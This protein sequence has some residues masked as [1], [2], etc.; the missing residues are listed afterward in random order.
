MKPPLKATA[1]M[2]WGWKRW[3]VLRVPRTTIC[4]RDS[5]S[6]AAGELVLRQES[7]EFRASCLRACPATIRNLLGSTYA[8]MKKRAKISRRKIHDLT[9]EKSLC[10]FA[11]PKMMWSL[12][13]VV[14]ATIS[15][16]P[17]YTQ[18]STKSEGPSLADSNLSSLSTERAL[19]KAGSAALDRH[20]SEAIK[21]L[22]T[23]LREH[24]GERALRLELGRAYL[25]TG[26]D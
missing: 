14:F 22:R 24:P 7:S 26:K 15:E 17:S 1:R 8:S 9:W 20:Y 3:I 19:A 4:C 6:S 5:P 21:I 23:A 18:T 10:R 12:L 25:A 16:S 13:L 2:K 11:V